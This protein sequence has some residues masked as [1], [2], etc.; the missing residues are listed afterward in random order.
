M[1]AL[2]AESTD[3]YVA[4]TASDTAPSLPEEVWLTIFSYLSDYNLARSVF[5]VCKLFREYASSAIFRRL[6]KS[7]IKL[8][9][10]WGQVHA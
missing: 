5:P 6:D 4:D 8:G 7:P 1:A 10:D 9:H 2:R 3:E